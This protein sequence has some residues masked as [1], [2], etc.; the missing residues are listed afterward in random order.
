MVLSSPFY[1]IPQVYLQLQR[2]CSSPRCPSPRRTP[3]WNCRSLSHLRLRRRRPH[4]PPAPPGCCRCTAGCARTN[5]QTLS[6]SHPTCPLTTWSLCTPTHSDKT[7]CNPGA[8]SCHLFV[9]LN[10]KLV[11]LN[12]K[13]VVLNCKLVV[14]NC[15]LVVLNCKLVVINCRLEVLNWIT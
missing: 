6:T 3:Y 8:F 15:K 7:H 2:S 5:A 14:L 9:V 1:L 4:P 11:V 12:C 10:C 13:L